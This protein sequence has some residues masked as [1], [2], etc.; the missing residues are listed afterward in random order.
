[1]PNLSDTPWNLTTRGERYFQIRIS[2]DT[3]VAIV[4]S[5]LVHL[6][7][8]FA[9][10]RQHWLDTPPSPAPEPITIVLNPVKPDTAAV[11]QAQ[12][13]PEAAPEPKPGKPYK[14]KPALIPRSKP[15]VAADEY[16]PITPV[17]PDNLAPPIP[18]AR[19]DS[20]MPTDMLAY[21][22]QARARRN[23]LE[24]YATQENAAAIAHQRGRTE[25]EIR[26]DNIRRN[27]LQ[28]TN[29]IFQITSMDGRNAQFSFRG[30]TNEYNARREYFEV[31]AAPAELERAVVRKMIELIRRY[32]NGDFNWESQRL[33]RVV[34]LSARQEDNAGLEDFLIQEFFRANSRLA[35]RQ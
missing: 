2:R 9:I 4:L 6:L 13:A 26:S 24:S 32:Y 8:I 10:P 27:F 31:E 28:G 21:I 3:F 11:S 34:I 33:G 19:P 25:E 5:I 18:S 23:A 20:A 17:I 30:W 29:G 15:A 1:V 7:L 12:P 35:P 22:N 16:L 14:P